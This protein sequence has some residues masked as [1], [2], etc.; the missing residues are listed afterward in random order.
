[1]KGN[2]QI[3]SDRERKVIDETSLGGNTKPLRPGTKAH[4]S[5]SSSDPEFTEHWGLRVW[6]P[7]LLVEG[8]W[9]HLVGILNR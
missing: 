3:T 4:P 1:M 5:I 6:S 9:H 7:D 2:G 8:Q